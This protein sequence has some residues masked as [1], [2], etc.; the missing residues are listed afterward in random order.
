MVAPNNNAPALFTVKLRPM[1]LVPNVN[2][3]TSVI[4]TSFAPV[5]LNE[6][7]PIKLLL[8]PLVVKSI[9]KLPVV[10]LDVPGTTIVPV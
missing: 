10:K 1:L 4:V 9:P 8:A 7:A 5:L 3:L 6:T 2:A